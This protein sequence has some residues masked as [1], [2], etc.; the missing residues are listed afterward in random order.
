M[1]VN[2]ANAGDE[3]LAELMHVQRLKKRIIGLLFWTLD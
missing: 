3:Y 1:A 2:A